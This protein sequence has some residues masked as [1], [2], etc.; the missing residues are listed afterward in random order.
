MED[1]SSASHKIAETADWGSL[2]LL[3]V[4]GCAIAAMFVAVVAL[5]RASK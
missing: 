3:A 5:E 2:A 4:A 1:V